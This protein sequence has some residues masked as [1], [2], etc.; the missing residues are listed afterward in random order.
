MRYLIAV[1]SVLI[2][3]FGGVCFFGHDTAGPIFFLTGAICFTMIIA[4]ND[5]VVAIEEAT[6]AMNELRKTNEKQ[7]A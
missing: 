4:A 6:K 2:F 1:V 3:L 5:I 7:K